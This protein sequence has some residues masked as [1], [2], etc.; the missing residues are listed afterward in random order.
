MKTMAVA[1]AII[2]LAVVALA[3]VFRS[4][5]AGAPLATSPPG[6]SECR[7][8]IDWADA[9]DKLGESAT[10]RGRVVTATYR[11]RSNGTPTFLNVG[12]PFPDPA[13]LVVVIFG[14]SRSK[15]PRPPERFYDGKDIAVTG[16]ITEFDGVTQVG[17]PRVNHFKALL[18]STFRWRWAC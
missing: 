15:F 12:L 8:A 14:D 17:R 4:G 13:R 7:D 11:A 3:F 2:V 16:Q 18:L 6:N 10:L 5:S 9:R 1:C